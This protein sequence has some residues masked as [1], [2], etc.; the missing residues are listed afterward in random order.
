VWDRENK[1]Q[2][3]QRPL[4]S[5]DNQIDVTTGTV[6]LKASFP[7]AGQAL[8]IQFGRAHGGRCAQ[9][10]GPRPSRGDPRRGSQGTV[11]VTS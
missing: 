10:S 3:A 7:I 9:G 8:P 5:T 11:V 1:V 6:R 4:V 2:L